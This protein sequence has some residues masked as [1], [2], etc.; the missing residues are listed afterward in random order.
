MTANRTRGQKAG[1]TREAV[2]EGAVRLVDRDGLAKLSMRRL[3]AEVGVEAMTLYNYFANKEALLDG[4]VEHVFSLATLSLE[5]D[6]SWQ[7]W[8]RGYARSLRATLLAHPSLMPAV[9]TRPAVTPQ[10]LRVME[11]GL[12]ELRK[13]GFPTRTAMDLVYSLTEFVVGHV[14]TSPTTVPDGAAAKEERLTGVDPQEFPL[15][16]EAIGT[17]RPQGEDAR[18]D[19]ALEAMFRGFADF[20]R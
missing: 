11:Y 9:I 2:L 6:A 8:L 12:R 7:A 1:L 17:P 13:A 14:A 3:G 5:E 10:S 15:I 20:I 4:L 18:F 19:V 16:A